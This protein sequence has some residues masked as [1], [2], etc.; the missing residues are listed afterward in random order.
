MRI[1]LKS[2]L[3]WV[4]LVLNVLF[5][6]F[7]IFAA[8]SD[9]IAVSFPAPRDAFLAAATVAHF[10]AS[11]ALVFNPVEFTLKTGE[12]VYLQY[13]VVT[14]KRQVNIVINALY[15]P[16]IIKVTQMGTGIEITALNAGETLMQSI[17]NEGI[18]D[19]AHII[20]TE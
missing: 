11:S 18:I 2:I 12:K 5:L 8:M 19:I 9:N 15:D 7:F 3:I 10:P 14:G 20:I 6:C 4:S 13:S 17:S 16:A 1:N